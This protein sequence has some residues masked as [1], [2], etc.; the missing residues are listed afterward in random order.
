MTFHRPFILLAKP[1]IALTSVPRSQTLANF[2]FRLV[3]DKSTR[4]SDGAGRRKQLAPRKE[5]KKERSR[6][7]FVPLCDLYRS[8]YREKVT[9]I[10]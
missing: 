3:G 7:A 1:T 10:K 2:V 9:E 5:K 6:H 8:P 4:A